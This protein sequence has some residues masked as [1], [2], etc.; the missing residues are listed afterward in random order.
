MVDNVDVHPGTPVGQLF[1]NMA[2]GGGRRVQIDGPYSPPPSQLLPEI[3]KN[4][5][6]IIFGKHVIVLAPIVIML[7]H[8]GYRIAYMASIG[9]MIAQG[10]RTPEWALL[11]MPIP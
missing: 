9:L 6:P 10:V 1:A 4:N 8:R 2:L 3:P 11:P 7:A 5:S